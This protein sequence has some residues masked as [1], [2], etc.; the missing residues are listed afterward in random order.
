MTELMEH[1]G[2]WDVDDRFVLPRLDD[3]VDH[4]HV[5][6]STVEQT[7]TY[8]DTADRDLQ[9]HGVTLQRCSGD[10]GGWELKTTGEGRTEFRADTSDTPPL[11]IVDLLSG[12]RLGKPLIEVATIRT[13]RER[14]R[15]TS[16]TDGLAFEVDDERVRASSGHN[17]LYGWRQI[18]VELGSGIRETP[19]KLAR[20]LAKAGAIPARFSSNSTASTGPAPFPSEIPP[21]GP[22]QSPPI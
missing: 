7:N 6:Q 1:A 10:D 4:A 21:R 14:Y 15:V 9:A 13:T 19:K 20:R 11:G 5:L 17:A 22:R 16:A 2:T 3:V 18:D 12:I 8:Y